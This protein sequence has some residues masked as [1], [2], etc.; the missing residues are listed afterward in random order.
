MSL[1][2]RTAV[3][4]A[5][6]IAALTSLLPGCTLGTEIRQRS[7]PDPQPCNAVIMSVRGGTSD[8]P[9]ALDLVHD[10][11]AVVVGEEQG[12]AEDISDLGAEDRI[13]SAALSPFDRACPSRI[14]YAC[15]SS[16]TSS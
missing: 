16:P 3:P 9:L 14:R 2:P 4:T 10:V 11:D 13:Q 15:V 5:M 12:L 1:T 8:E 6:L 7:D